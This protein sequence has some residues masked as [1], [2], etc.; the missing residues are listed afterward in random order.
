MGLGM[1]VVKGVNGMCLRMHTS[2]QVRVCFH[3]SPGRSVYVSQRVCVR[4]VFLSL[5]CVYFWTAA[6]GHSA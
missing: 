6:S 3:L 2:V 1:S 5:V 4:C